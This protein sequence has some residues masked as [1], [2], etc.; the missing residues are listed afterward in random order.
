M[1]TFD[2]VAERRVAIDELDQAIV[3]LTARINA[4]SYELL[5]LIRQ[6]DERAG[7]LRWGFSNCTEW[8]HWRCDLSPSA[9]REKVRVAHALK[10]LPE[11]STTFAQ[12]VLSYSKV[13][14]LTRVATPHNESSLVS[15]AL[16]T[17][18]ARVEE[19]C[20]QLRNVQP[21][22]GNEANRVRQQRALR[23]WRNAERGMMTLTVELPIE[24]GEL[25]EQA[26]TKAMEKA[27]ANGSEFEAESFA[28]RQADGLVDIA[29][30]YLSGSASSRASTAEHYQVVVHVDE[31][32][33]TEGEGRSD[34]PLE[35]VK[36]LSCDG[37]IVGIV[38]GAGGEPL[39]VGRKQR[40][41]PTAIKRAL[42]ARDRSCRFPGCGNTRFAD[43]HHIRHWA[44]GG[45]TSLDNLMLLCSRHHQ[46]G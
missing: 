8:L 36:R 30:E 7:W 40:S 4:A 5:M 34:L 19:R 2:A 25:I 18:A 43:A 17:T 31:S 23:V 21:R 24:Q 37:S 27:P 45:E 16:T 1:N 28:A 46:Q 6:F 15:F 33:L 12:G 32:A 39:S 22:S 13:R 9:A 20:R 11:I 38:D 14:A 29:S 35:S 26:L 44:D 3:N 41:V 10:D 42:W